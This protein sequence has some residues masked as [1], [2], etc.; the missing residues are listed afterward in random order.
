MKA[1][2]LASSLYGLG[3]LCGAGAYKITTEGRQFAGVLIGELCKQDRLS[4]LD[5]NQLAEVFYACAEMKYKH[6]WAFRLICTLEEAKIQDLV[7]ARQ[8][9]S[10]IDHSKP[11][12]SRRSTEPRTFLG[13]GSM[14]A[15]L[16]LSMGSLHFRVESTVKLLMDLLE[17]DAKFLTGKQVAMCLKGMYKLDYWPNGVVSL[18]SSRLAEKSILVGLS[19]IDLQGIL[20]IFAQYR[21]KDDSIL[22]S[23]WSEISHEMRL[24]NFTKEGLLSIMDSLWKLNYR[25]LHA[26]KLLGNH[27][28]EW[29]DGPDFSPEDLGFLVLAFGKAGYR[30]DPFL[31]YVSNQVCID[32]VLSKFASRNLVNLCY[33]LSLVGFRDAE[34]LKHLANEVIDVNRLDNYTQDQLSSFVYS[35]GR[36]RYRNKVLFDALAWEISN[37]VRLKAFSEQNL[38]IILWG[39]GKI[40]YFNKG[41]VEATVIEAATEKRLAVYTNQGLV[42][43]IYCMGRLNY[44]NPWVL[45]CIGKEAS[46]TKRL[47]TF[48]GQAMSNIAFAYGKLDF[49]FVPLML[50]LNREL[51]KKKRLV[52]FNELELANLMYGL[53]ELRFSFPDTIKVLELEISKITRLKQFT[54]PDLCNLAFGFSGMQRY[55]CA[56]LE[57]YI[58]EVLKPER[59][60]AFSDS[61]LQAITIRLEDIPAVKSNVLDILAKEITARHDASLDWD[62]PIFRPWKGQ[63]FFQ[64]PYQLENEPT[65]E[66]IVS[67]LTKFVKVQQE[68]EQKEGQGRKR[69]TGIDLNENRS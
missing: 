3:Q 7:T 55:V 25:K 66:E 15:H 5:E 11:S 30:H 67:L 59:M 24:S 12:S 38:S 17:W 14:I 62:Y 6:F 65:E 42:N 22:D 53:G 8:I 16:L 18:L 9:R 36:L 68:R 64:P 33:G 27:I 69:W 23:L 10:K 28:V 39:Y 52:S 37:E 60:E 46:N 19:N 56:A 35:F 61:E 21:F 13:H 41:T 57:A 29:G 58:D 48:T 4:S 44:R 40:Q 1:S 32:G 49:R 47:E 26:W 63:W 43:I 20:E 45:V 31:K 51:S 54:G 2:I 50:G 34:M